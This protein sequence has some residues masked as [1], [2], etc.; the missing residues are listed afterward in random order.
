MQGGAVYNTMRHASFEHLSTMLSPLHPLHTPISQYPTTTHTPRGHSPPSSRC[1]A[2]QDP[3]K[4]PLP[5]AG[6]APCVTAWGVAGEQVL[7]VQVSQL[8][9]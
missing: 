7:R 2:F 6:T 8:Q 1:S 4:A 9:S 3:A 5:L